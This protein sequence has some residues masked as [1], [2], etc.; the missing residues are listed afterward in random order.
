M[1]SHPDSISISDVFTFLAFLLSSLEYVLFLASFDSSSPLLHLGTESLPLRRKRWP[2]VALRASG[3]FLP[4]AGMS[5]WPLEHSAVPMT[6]HAGPP[7]SLRLRVHGWAPT[8]PMQRLMGATVALNC[9]V[10]RCNRSRPT[11]SWCTASFFS[12]NFL[13]AET[14]IFFFLGSC[15]AASMRSGQQKTHTPPCG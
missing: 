15:T 14:R 2:A 6:A 4:S 11:A 9:S 10:L 12:L 5:F 13:S 3:T 1:E 8:P 7:S